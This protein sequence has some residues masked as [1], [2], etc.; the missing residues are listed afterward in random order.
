MNINANRRACAAK[1]EK[2]R[3][4]DFAI[5]ETVLYLDAYPQNQQALSYY[6][7]LIKQRNRLMEEYETTCGPLT[8]YGNR[9]ANSWDWI[10]APW[11]WEREANETETR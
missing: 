3:A 1:L 11:P 9:S 4:L 7:Q 5:Q 8:M 2:L 6:H 10:E